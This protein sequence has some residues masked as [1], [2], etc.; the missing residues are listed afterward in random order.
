[1]DTIS[2]VGGKLRTLTIERPSRDQII[3]AANLASANGIGITGQGP[4]KRITGVKVAVVVGPGGCT[5]CQAR[6]GVWC[7]HRSLYALATQRP[8]NIV[9]FPAIERPRPAA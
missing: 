6:R 4:F 1:M 8:S 3:V 5:C 9:T 2:I 7:H